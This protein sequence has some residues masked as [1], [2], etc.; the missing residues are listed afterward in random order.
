LVLRRTKVLNAIFLDIDGVINNINT[1]DYGNP[2]IKIDSGLVQKLSDI[3]MLTNSKIFLISDWKEYWQK[4]N[5]EE[6]HEIANYI[7]YRLSCES[8]TIEDKVDGQ[9]LTRGSNIK[10]FLLSQEINN[11]V[12]LDDM[13]FD[14]K[15]EGLAKNFVHT[16]SEH[17]LTDEDVA[18]AI[19]I[20]T[21][22]KI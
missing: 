7:D 5:K 21:K 17:G 20:L 4:D 16:N 22:N 9:K 6:Q 14:Y 2:Y 15:K 12:I 19:K 8:L 10:N 1:V 13:P 3:V 18:R 11:F